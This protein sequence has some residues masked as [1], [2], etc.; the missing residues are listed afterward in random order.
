MFKITKDDLARKTDAQLFRSVS[1]SGQRHNPRQSGLFCAAIAS[2]EDR[3]RTREAWAASIAAV[4]GRVSR[5][6]ILA[7]KKVKAGGLPLRS[8]TIPAIPLLH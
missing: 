5:P 1:G 8:S 7:I 4:K 3:S 6:F 2:G